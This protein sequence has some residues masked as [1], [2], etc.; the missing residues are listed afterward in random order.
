[1]KTRR[2]AGAIA[3]LVATTL[4]VSACGSP[5]VA[6]PDPTPDTTATQPGGDGGENGGAPAIEQH[7]NIGWNQP[8][9]SQNNLTAMG[10]ATANAIVLYL[11]N[12][13]LRYYDGDVLLQPRNDMG[14]YEISEDGLEL[15]VSVNEGVVWSD[16]VPVD[17]ADLILYWG[18]Q[19][20]RFNTV[21]GET[22]CDLV[23]CPLI[24]CEVDEDGDQIDE[25]CD[26][27]EQV[28]PD[29]DPTAQV[30][31]ECI[32]GVPTGA[33]F[34][35]GVSAMI[36]Q[37]SAFPALD[38]DGRTVVFT[39]DEF[40][41]SWPYLFGVPPIAAHVVAR[42]ALGIDDPTEA[43][44]ALIDAFRT[45]D[46]EALAA[47]ASVWNNDFNFTS[48]PSEPELFLATGAFIIDQFAEG[49]YMT[50]V[51][52]PYYAT[53]ADPAYIPTID[54]ITLT[55]QED[56]MTQLIAVQNY[57]VDLTAPQ[58][59]VDTLAFAQSLTNASYITAVG[60]TWEHVDLVVNNYGPFDPAA[61]G[62][63]E[64]AARM[65]RQAFL[66]SIPRDQIVSTLIDP[67]APGSAVRNSFLWV[68]G[69]AG[70]QASVP[71][72]GSAAFANV[73]T[74]LAVD[75]IAQA[76]ELAPGGTFA[77]GDI[78]VRLLFGAGNVRRE[79][80]FQIITPSAA[81]AG[82][83]MIDESSTDWGMRISTDTMNYDAALFG[84]QSTNTLLNNGR[85]NYE[86]EGQNNPYGWTNPRIDELWE[87][88]SNM[89]DDT[90]PEAVAA[91]VEIEQ[92]VWDEA[93]TVPIFQFPEVVV[94]TNR[95]ANVSQIPLSP[96]IFWNFWEWEIVA[97]N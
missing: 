97:T 57:Q 84:W 41:N 32:P 86:T 8:F 70:Y 15:T 68:P 14:S 80:Q 96:T 53:W 66:H 17:A 13:Q 47:I 3:A 40:Q 18:A 30:D 82:F 89:V 7:I 36:G 38:A 21:E 59:T 43:K 64:E 52:N 12:Q 39:F 83:Q 46:T 88:I 72:N 67:V 11:T 79:N 45:N 23:Q 2:I 74:A 1:M 37:M 71:Q 77:E 19:N 49:Q 48:L 20:P 22:V 50:F 81:A 91:G 24:Q 56:P 61:W 75:L 95:V 73:D 76:R 87:Q 29:C 42:R 35:S 55:W 31:P 33:V 90:S 5:E 10:N 63:N 34:F 27:T 65:V 62:G 44:A 51:R 94:H 85:A 28:D 25:E 9:F 4:V 92:L 58:A 69:S 78:P 16:G 54:T 26:P 6:P 60:A 93:W